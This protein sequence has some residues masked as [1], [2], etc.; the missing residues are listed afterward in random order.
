MKKKYTG[1]FL[2]FIFGYTQVPFGS[3]MYVEEE[4]T[5]SMTAVNFLLPL[6]GRLVQFRR[7]MENLERVFVNGEQNASLTVLYFTDEGTNDT[8]HKTI[9]NAMADKH[10]AL[11]LKWINMEGRFSR[12]LALTMGASQFDKTELLFFCDVD[13]EFDRGFMD[14]CRSNAL[15]DKQVS[16]SFF[17]TRSFES[18]FC[19]S[20]P[21]FFLEWCPGL[22]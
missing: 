1:H 9:F 7:F 17:R 15:L 19:F 4:K 3:L 16:T 20:A 13:L 6:A 8:D 10:P 14:R 11:K 12:A 2:Y 22:D 5:T 21:L 18:L